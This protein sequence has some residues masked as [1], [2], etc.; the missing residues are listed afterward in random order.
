MRVAFPAHPD[1]AI[2]ALAGTAACPG[3][4]LAWMVVHARGAVASPAAD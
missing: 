3:P 4:A 1:D 2:A